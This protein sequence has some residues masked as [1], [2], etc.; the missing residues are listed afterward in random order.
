MELAR[1]HAELALV[2]GQCDCDWH[3]AV[4]H[5]AE[6]PVEH[7]VGHLVMVGHPVEGP[8]AMLTP[9]LLVVGLWAAAGVP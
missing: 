4:K 1:R 7:P 3:P 5:P 8:V 9:S 2:L 6:H